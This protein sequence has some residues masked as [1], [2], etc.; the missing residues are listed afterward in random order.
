[1]LI[2][3]CHFSRFGRDPEVNKMSSNSSDSFI[4]NGHLSPQRDISPS[5]SYSV[6]ADSEEG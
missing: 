5:T 2:Q 6:N 1:M 3:E 4:S